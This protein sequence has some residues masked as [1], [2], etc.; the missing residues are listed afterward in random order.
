MIVL[1][2]KAGKKGNPNAQG[3][4]YLGISGTNT[5]GAYIGNIGNLKVSTV[6]A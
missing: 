6:R 3:E 2:E 4:I 1:G 5:Q